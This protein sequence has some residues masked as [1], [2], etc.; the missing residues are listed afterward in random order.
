MLASRD[1]AAD[2]TL[3]NLPAPRR[4]DAVRQPAGVSAI[5]RLTPFG[6]KCLQFL[7]DRS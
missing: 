5:L 4:I 1:G 7:A 2:V 6:W 3:A